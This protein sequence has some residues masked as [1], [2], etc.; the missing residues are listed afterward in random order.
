MA[1]NFLPNSPAYKPREAALALEWV[2]GHVGMS[3]ILKN[4]SRSTAVA[5]KV[6]LR[7]KEEAAQR[8]PSRLPTPGDAVKPLF[9]GHPKTRTAFPNKVLFLHCLVR[10]Q[11]ASP[12]AR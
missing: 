3:P 7:K 8:A 5:F 12:A 2:S 10:A 6:T 11:S 9:P 1:T 4:Q